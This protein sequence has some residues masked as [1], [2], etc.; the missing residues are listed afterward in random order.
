M[1]DLDSR[2]ITELQEAD[3]W[4]WGRGLESGMLGRRTVWS[5][6]ERRRGPS[7]VND[8]G[9]GAPQREN[10]QNLGTESEVGE[11]GGGGDEAE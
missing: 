7:H 4:G 9:A 6:G 5:S 2:K 1:P 8:R 3:G 11:G 10:W